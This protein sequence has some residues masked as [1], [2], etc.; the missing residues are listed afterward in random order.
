MWYL[1]STVSHINR[2]WVRNRQVLCYMCSVYTGF[3]LSG[4]DWERFFSVYQCWQ[5]LS[6]LCSIYTW[7]QLSVFVYTDF[8]LS[9]FDLDGLSVI[10]VRCIRRGFCYQCS[11]YTGFLLSVFDLDGVSVISVRFRQ[12]YR[13]IRVLQ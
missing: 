11:M 13:I 10:S 6:Y 7:F 4:F 2:R 12:V 1:G 9:V 3:P 5:I 8:L